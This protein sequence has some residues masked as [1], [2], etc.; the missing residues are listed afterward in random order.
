MGS[1]VSAS[2]EKNLGENFVTEECDEGSCEEF[3]A[4]SLRIPVR[5]KNSDIRRAERFLKD[6][7]VKL[8]IKPEKLDEIR[9]IQRQHQSLE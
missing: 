6:N 5:S 2:D 1:V 9:N 3:G 7:R 8:A 4:D